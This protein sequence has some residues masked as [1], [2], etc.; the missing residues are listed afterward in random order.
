MAVTDIKSC[1]Q[2][3]ANLSS[4]SPTGAPSEVMR[5]CQ[6]CGCRHFEVTIDRMSVGLRSAVP[7]VSAGH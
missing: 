7:N 4:P 5:V 6:V 1:C 3:T 2:D